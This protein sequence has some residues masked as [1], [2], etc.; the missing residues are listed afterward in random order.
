MILTLLS[1]QNITHT[2]TIQMLAISDPLTILA[3]VTPVLAI[4]IGAM[5]FYL[6][7][8]RDQQKSARNDALRRV[9]QI[10]SAIRRLNARFADAELRFATKEDWLRESMLTRQSITKL[11][12]SA[13]SQR[14]AVDILLTRSARVGHTKTHNSIK[15]DGE[16]EQN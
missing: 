12:E 14:A 3:A 8:L 5:T 4:P 13:A 16:M 1:T 2:G 6:R 15:I 9:E 7:A 11:S 10:E